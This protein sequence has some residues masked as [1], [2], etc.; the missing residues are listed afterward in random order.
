MPT[1]E[2]PE[3]SPILNPEQQ[4]RHELDLA[5]KSL[6]VGEK[7]EM[8]DEMKSKI[9]EMIEMLKRNGEKF[10]MSVDRAGNISREYAEVSS[11]GHR[12]DARSQPHTDFME[13]MGHAEYR[14]YAYSLADRLS[15]LVS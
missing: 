1:P 14:D 6:L 13:F 9:N 3:A 8:T 7:I 5:I 15:K 4:K 11:L 12:I 2:M 10:N